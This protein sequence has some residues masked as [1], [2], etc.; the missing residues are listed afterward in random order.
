MNVLVFVDAVIAITLLEAAWLVWWR[1]RGLWSASL[2]CTLASGLCLMLA[3]RAALAGAGPAWIVAAVSA[4]G[5][6][7]VADVVMRHHKR[8]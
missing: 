4:A 8:S 7:H 3:L 2:A 1:W 6:A 5:V